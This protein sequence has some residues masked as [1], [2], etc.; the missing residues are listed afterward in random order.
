M[1]QAKLMRLATLWA[2]TATALSG[3]GGSGVGEQD[4]PQPEAIAVEGGQ[5]FS[6]TEG[7]IQTKVRAGAEV[8]WSGKESRKGD[9]DSGLPIIR[10][11]WGQQNP[12]ANPVQLGDRASH[13]VSFTAPR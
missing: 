9:D 10:Y 13:T 5:S 3:C 2:L 7:G 11:E 12:G 1:G 8:V 6:R 4:E